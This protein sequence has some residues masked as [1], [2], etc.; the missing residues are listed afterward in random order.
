MS[1]V[2][3]GEEGSDVYVFYSSEGIECCGCKQ[4]GRSVSYE[5]ERRMIDHL[6]VHRERG[7]YV[8]PFVFDDLRR[9]EAG[10]DR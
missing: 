9:E 6:L 8:P 2:R 7:D 3:F 10:D 5:D 1:I 4:V